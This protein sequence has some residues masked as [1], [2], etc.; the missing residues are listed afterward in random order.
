MATPQLRETN[1]HLDRRAIQVLLIEVM[2]GESR[3]ASSFVV[4]EGKIKVAWKP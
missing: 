4:R 1:Q 2:V 3:L